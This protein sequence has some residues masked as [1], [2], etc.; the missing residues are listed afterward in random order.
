MYDSAL[1]STRSIGLSTAWFSRTS[2]PGA[3][4]GMKKTMRRLRSICANARKVSCAREAKPREAA[5]LP[6]PIVGRA[7][8]AKR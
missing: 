7:V 8:M 6:A 4:S 2:I 1:H 5:G 3:K